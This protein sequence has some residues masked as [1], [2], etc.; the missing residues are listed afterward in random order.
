MC[1][2]GISYSSEG[3]VW[4][5]NIPGWDNYPLFDEVRA[6]AGNLP[7]KIDSDRACYMLGELWKG[8]AKACNNAIFMAI[9]TGIGAGILVNG[10]IFRG[11]NDIAGSIG[12][13]GLNKPYKSKY[14]ECGCFEYHASGEGIAKVAGEYIS[15]QSSYK[16]QLARKKNS[17]ISSYD[18]MDAFNNGDLLAQEVINECIEYWG[19][20][21]ANMVS[22]FNPEKIILGG[23][24]FG[25]AK[26]LIPEIKKEAEKWAQPIS[27]KHVI[28]DHSALGSD[29]GVYGA[30]YMALKNLP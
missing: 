5:P 16:G 3:T 6:I 14:K 29:A 24:L 10:E 30:A 15:Q 12:W 1:V 9:G 17:K 4:A 7:V 28:L 13:M 20:A 8:N 26:S 2:P 19:M 18:V 27:I 11:S 23:G 21:V 22:I 25:P